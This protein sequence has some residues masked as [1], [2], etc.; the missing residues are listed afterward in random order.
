MKNNSVLLRLYILFL[1]LFLSCLSSKINY[2]RKTRI[3]PKHK[4]LSVASITLG[5]IF[6]RL[7][8]RYSITHLSK[9][10]EAKCDNGSLL[11]NWMRI[12]RSNSKM[13]TK[14]SK[15]IFY[16]K[17]HWKVNQRE[18]IRIFR[19]FIKS[20]IKCGRVKNVK[21]ALRKFAFAYL[22]IHKVPTI[23]LVRFIVQLN[24]IFFAQKY[25]RR[26]KDNTSIY[27][28]GLLIKM[29]NYRKQLVNCKR[30]RYLCWFRGKKCLQFKKICY[31]VNRL[32]QKLNSEIIQSFST[33]FS[34]LFYDLISYINSPTFKRK[35][36]KQLTRD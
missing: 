9:Q 25:I 19:K 7:G 33:H 23:K 35:S 30:H 21:F 8:Y 17:K 31:E 3:N 6:K 12:I 24:R 2:K 13:I 28:Y 15:F 32:R 29:K 27:K 5:N 26:S 36:N 18:R 11:R 14:S 16:R 10:I 22:M 4:N 1:I 20:F 34:Q